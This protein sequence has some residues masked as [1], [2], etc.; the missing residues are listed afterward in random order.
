MSKMIPLSARISEDDLEF[1]SQLEVEGC[2]TPSE[3]IRALVAESRTRYLGGFEYKTRLKA[4]Q[5]D[6]GKLGIAI[7]EI[8]NEN[9]IHSEILTTVLNWL[10]DLMAYIVT[11][12]CRLEESPSEAELI[13]LE[14]AVVGRVFGL[15]QS[16]AQMGFSPDIPSY[17]AMAF[18]KKLQDLAE[19]FQLLGRLD[20]MQKPQSTKGSSS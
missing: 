17:D 19:I 13:K 12:E 5:E 1:L 14:K 16:V 20:A 9:N 6:L 4:Y 11:S 8:E 2:T 7:R 10:P 18:K 3:K 15:A